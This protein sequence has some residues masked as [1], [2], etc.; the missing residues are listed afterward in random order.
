MIQRYLQVWKYID[1]KTHSQT[2]LLL[3][4]LK[5]PFRKL[6]FFSTFLYKRHFF[7]MNKIFECYVVGTG[8]HFQT[9]FSTQSINLL[10]SFLEINLVFKLKQLIYFEAKRVP[11]LLTFRVFQATCS[12]LHNLF[13]VVFRD[14]DLS[15][16][17]IK[18]CIMYSCCQTTPDAGLNQD[19]APPVWLDQSKFKVYEFMMVDLTLIPIKLCQTARRFIWFL[20]I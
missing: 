5:L 10:K 2:L 3:D 18:N 9:L 4:L 15:E 1:K 17:L 19:D 6:L 7:S 11:E 13:D 12:K 14:K 20:Q 8:F 16:M